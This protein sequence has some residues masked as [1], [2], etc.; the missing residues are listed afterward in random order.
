MSVCLSASLSVMGVNCLTDNTIMVMGEGS[1]FG[2]YCWP[3]SVALHYCAYD[4]WG[5]YHVQDCPLV[6]I[7]TL[8]INSL[9]AFHDRQCNELAI[10]LMR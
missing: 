3:P 10:E 7:D 2:Y 4:E 5:Y 8:L 6:S 1:Q 9:I